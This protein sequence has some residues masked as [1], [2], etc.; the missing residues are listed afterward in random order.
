MAKCILG[1]LAV[2]FIG[3][4]FTNEAE[5]GCRKHRLRKMI[6][7][8]ICRCSLILALFLMAGSAKAQYVIS[9]SVAVGGFS[10]FNA[11]GC[12]VNAAFANSGCGFN[13][14]FIQPNFGFA[15]ATPFAINNRVIVNNRGF[16]GNFFRGR[17]IRGPRIRSVTRTR[18][19]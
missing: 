4:A 3:F 19:R 8:L 9:N 15:A 11:S 6:R 10:S 1:L 17:G 18:I 12:G 14:V 7:N 13:S 16:G 2:L 5:A